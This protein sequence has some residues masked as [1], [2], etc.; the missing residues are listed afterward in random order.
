MY[1]ATNFIVNKVVFTGVPSDLPLDIMVGVKRSVCDGVVTLSV[2]DI[3]RARG[4]VALAHLYEDLEAYARTFE[5][6]E[7]CNSLI[8]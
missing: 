7:I 5:V 8:T 1:L 4:N 3:V 6:M 2:T